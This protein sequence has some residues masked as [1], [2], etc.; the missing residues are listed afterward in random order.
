VALEL[1]F[2]YGSGDDA[3][4]QTEDDDL[5][6][7]SHHSWVYKA[8]LCTSVIVY[9]VYFININTPLI[10]YITRISLL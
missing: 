7:I 9:I 6:K 5:E 4:E 8:H 3:D 1:E 10:L 2:V